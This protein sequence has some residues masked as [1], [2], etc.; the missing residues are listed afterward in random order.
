MIDLGRKVAPF[1]RSR[2]HT[3]A[4]ANCAA[5][6]APNAMIVRHLFG[7]QSEFF[8]GSSSSHATRS[9]ARRATARSRP[10]GV[11]CPSRT[12]RAKA[13]R[14]SMEVPHN[15]IM[16]WNSPLIGDRD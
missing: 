3:S 10:S 11:R 14:A 16:R 13:L 15:A 4:A 12:S 6:G 2:H 8:V 7:E 5:C 9:Y 1:G